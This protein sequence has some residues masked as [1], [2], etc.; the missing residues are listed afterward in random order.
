MA[1]AYKKG[2]FVE[3]ARKWPSAPSAIPCGDAATTPKPHTSLSPPN[4]CP[5]VSN[6]QS[7]QGESMSKREA[8]KRCSWMARGHKPLFVLPRNKRRRRHGLRPNTRLGHTAALTLA[9]A[10][11]LTCL[12]VKVIDYEVAVGYNT[13]PCSRGATLQ[14]QQLGMLALGG[15]V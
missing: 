14:V 12:S 2:A 9:L 8:A 11:W 5:I 4:P 7:E 15:C 3:E 13:W 6:G 1:V 10:E